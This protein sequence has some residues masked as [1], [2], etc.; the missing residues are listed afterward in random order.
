MECS[1]T[2]HVHWPGPQIKKCN[3]L[4]MSLWNEDSILQESDLIELVFWKMCHCPTW[5]ATDSY[6]YL[7]VS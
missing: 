1:K 6:T 3:E 5:H 7:L 2:G 4:C